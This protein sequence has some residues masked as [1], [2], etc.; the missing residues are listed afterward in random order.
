MRPYY[1]YFD[2]ERYRSRGP[3]R[4]HDEYTLR[5]AISELLQAGIALTRQWRKRVRDR[6]ELASLDHQMR[7]DI[8]ICASE[9]AR[10]CAKPFWRA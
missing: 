10:E 7:R 2:F 6:Q 1:Y 3:Y 8:G 4:R 9:I 5:R